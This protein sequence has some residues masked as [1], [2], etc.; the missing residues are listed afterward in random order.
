VLCDR[1]RCRF[2]ASDNL[3]LLR[4]SGHFSEIGSEHAARVIAT[5]LDRAN[6]GVAKLRASPQ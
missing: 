6:W 5:S 2:T 1:D 4:D 3:P